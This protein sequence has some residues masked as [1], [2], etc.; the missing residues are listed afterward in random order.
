MLISLWGFYWDNQTVHLAQA[1]K[2]SYY[3]YRAE[4]DTQLFPFQHCQ[5]C[6]YTIPT[7]DPTKLNRFSQKSI[8]S[9]IL[10]AQTGSPAAWQAQLH[11]AIIEIPQN[12]QWIFFFFQQATNFNTCIDSNQDVFSSPFFWFAIKLLRINHIYK[13][14]SYCWG[15]KNCYDLRQSDW[16]LTEHNSNSFT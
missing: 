5:L 3:G 7:L 13:N 16:T 9:A 4:T 14:T 1:A 2:S 11:N 10:Q 8:L 12:Y 6:R 15:W